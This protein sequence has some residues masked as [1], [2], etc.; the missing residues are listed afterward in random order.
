MMLP[1]AILTQRIRV[2]IFARLFIATVFLFY[3]QF[4]FPTERILFY[5]IIAACCGLSIIYVLWLISAK[6]LTA[7][8]WFQIVCDLLLESALV[9]YTGGADSLFATIYV[10]SILSAGPVLSPAAGFFVAAGSSIC[11]IGAVI[12]YN[13]G[14]ITVAE[15]AGRRDL[16]YLFYASYVRITVFFLVAILTYYF[17]RMIQKLEDRVKTQERLVF[18]GEV[19]S[20]IAHE[21]RNPLASISGSVEL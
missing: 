5:S 4:V 7:L 14:G 19:I 17:S 15:P 12:L 20:S 10:L 1:V 3:A 6:H 16:I 21:I 2:L 18:L 11:F 9:A 13:S 8:A